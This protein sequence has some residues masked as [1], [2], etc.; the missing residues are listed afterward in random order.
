AGLRSSF[1]NLENQ[2]LSFVE[3]FFTGAA[4][5]SVGAVGDFVADPDQLTQRGALADDLRVRLDVRHGRR[6]LRQLTEVGKSADLR[7]VPF[8]VQLLGQ[9]H[10]VERRIA[11]SQNEDGTKN[12]TM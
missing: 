9:G 8:L 4:L 12:Q 7:Q 1:G 10:H 5:R 3:N 11:F 6:V 2:S